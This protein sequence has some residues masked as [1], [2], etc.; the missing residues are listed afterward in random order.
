M[1]VKMSA[2]PKYISAEEVNKLVDQEEL[3]AALENAFGNF[4]RGPDGGVVQPVRSIIEV[5]QH[6][7]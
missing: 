1:P 2:T 6:K 7:G 5:T 3:L 4:S